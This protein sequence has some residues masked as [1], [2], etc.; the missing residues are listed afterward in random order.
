MSE[1]VSDAWTENDIKDA[2]TERIDLN[3]K[4]LAETV[5]DDVASEIGTETEPVRELLERLI[6]AGLVHFD[7]S[8]DG[9]I[10]KL[11]S[12]A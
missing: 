1:T 10:V 3:D 4:P 11:P 8:P 7:D 9:R 2:I 6:E 5:I 12:D